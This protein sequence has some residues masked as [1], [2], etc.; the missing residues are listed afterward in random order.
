[1]LKN[2]V[3][4]FI[5]VITYLS[6]SLYILSALS[7]LF[8]RYVRYIRLRYYLV[9]SDF[10]SPED[11]QSIPIITTQKRFTSTM[12]SFKFCLKTATINIVRKETKAVETKVF[13]FPYLIKILESLQTTDSCLC[14]I[15]NTEIGMKQG[16]E[17]KWVFT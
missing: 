3:S 17:T 7:T 14:D 15:T 11:H 10:L 1:M 16:C 8:G 13:L 5:T 12:Q 2:W 9:F 6:E 4:E